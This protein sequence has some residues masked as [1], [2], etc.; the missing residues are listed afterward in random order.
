MF[1]LSNPNIWLY[2]LVYLFNRYA[3]HYVL[4]IGLTRLTGH[5]PAHEHMAHVGID[6]QL[7]F[8]VYPSGLCPE[9]E[10]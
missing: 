8:K 6:N 1:L 2:G 3:K 7:L 4:G 5:S 10:T 9:L